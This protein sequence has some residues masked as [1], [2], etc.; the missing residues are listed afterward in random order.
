M[1]KLVTALDKALGEDIQALPWMSEPTKK[2]AEAKLAAMQRKIGY[3][4]HWRDYSTLD[5]EP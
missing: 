3:P 2:E 5:R 4:E 1:E